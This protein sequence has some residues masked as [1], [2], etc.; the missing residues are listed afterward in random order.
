VI[1]T[2]NDARAEFATAGKASATHTRQTSKLRSMADLHELKKAWL[3]SLAPAFDECPLW[4][5][6]GHSDK[7]APFPLYPQ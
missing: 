1:S 7:P 6:S 5:I 4:V 2:G 3:V